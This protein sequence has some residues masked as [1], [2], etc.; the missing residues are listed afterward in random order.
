MRGISLSIVSQ[1]NKTFEYIEENLQNPISLEQLSLTTNLSVFQLIRLFDRFIGMT[2]K[3][4]IRA[5]RLASSLPQLLA[6]ESILSVA[7]DCGF[8]YE[9][10]Y[11]RAF[12]DCY[13]ITPARF[14][15]HGVS[16]EIVEVP[17]LERFTVSADGMVGEAKLLVRPAFTL[18]GELKCYHTL[19]NLLFGKSLLEGIE[20]CTSTIYTAACRNLSP[21]EFSQHYLVQKKANNC[22][23][24]D[25]QFASG[26]WAN[27]EY[28]GLHPLNDSG[29]TRIRILMSQV[30]GNWFT[31]NGIYWDGHFI[32]S[33]NLDKCSDN[34]CEIT[35][36]C[37]THTFS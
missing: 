26:Q 9:Q 20:G 24:V 21:G 34:Y 16:I 19:E 15:K 33:V 37:C 14:R 4:Y 1:I 27:F 29:V 28:I 32:E 10:S 23:L 8:Q 35:F 22:T 30:I 17:T 13:G 12:K 11:I 3:A 6:G 31:D 18:S 5:R 2:P 36:S 25:W 7:L